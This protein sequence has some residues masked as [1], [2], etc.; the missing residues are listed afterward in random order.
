MEVIVDLA[1]ELL[2]EQG[3]GQGGGDDHGQQHQ[4]GGHDHQLRPQG[5]GLPEPGELVERP[6][7]PGAVHG[8]RHAFKDTDPRDQL[9]P[10]TRRDRPDQRLSADRSR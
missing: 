9:S 10:A 8:C 5:G 1:D 6:E 3:G 2:P 4:A 7:A